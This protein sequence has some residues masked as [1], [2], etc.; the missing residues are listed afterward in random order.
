MAILL[1]VALIIVTA[2]I[3]IIMFSQ[4]IP[5]IMDSFALPFEFFLSMLGINVDMRPFS[6]DEEF[7]EDE[8]PCEEIWDIGEIW[9]DLP[10]ACHRIIQ[11]IFSAGFICLIY[12]ELSSHGIGDTSFEIF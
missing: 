2:I 10:L 5:P 1:I 9:E 4:I 3:L 11:L 8:D 6:E 12:S 7:I